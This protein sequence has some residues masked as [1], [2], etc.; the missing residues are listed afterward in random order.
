MLRTVTRQ[1]FRFG[2]QLKC[3]PYSQKTFNDFVEKLKVKESRQDECLIK[4]KEYI[5]NK[6]INLVLSDQLQLASL[7]KMDKELS[8]QYNKSLD[9]QAWMSFISGIGGIGGSLYYENGIPFI[10]GCLSLAYWFYVGCVLCE[11]DKLKK[12][13]DAKLIEF[14]KSL[15]KCQKN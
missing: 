8:S 11:T 7:E 3:R 14:S 12:C 15:D 13:Y 10:F 2:S 6:Q 1:T 4:V 9:T 5:A